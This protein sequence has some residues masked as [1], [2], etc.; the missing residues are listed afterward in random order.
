[1]GV[2]YLDSLKLQF[3]VQDLLLVHRGNER[4]L[5]AAFPRELFR[6][7][8]RNGFRVPMLRSTPVARVRHPM[9]PDMQLALR[10]LDIGI[11][12]CALFLPDDVPPLDPGV[13][14]NG[15]VIELDPDTRLGADL[16]LQHVTA[17]NP[18]SGGARLGCEIVSPGSEVSRALQRYID[19]TQKRRSLR[20]PA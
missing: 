19:Q 6:F 9:L 5:N 4:A 20:T 18:Q 17:I 15:V 8:R 16:R 10:V 14:L 12:G 2:G 7:Q 1:M 13:L 3:D 11:G